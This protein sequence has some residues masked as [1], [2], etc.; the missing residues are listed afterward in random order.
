MWS[1]FSYFV[2]TLSFLT[3]LAS[4][5][6]AD[7]RPALSS[8]SDAR[9]FLHTLDGDT[10]Q[11]DIDEIWRLRLASGEDEPA[12]AIVVDYAFERL[13]VKD[14]FDHLIED[15]RG[16]RKI[17]RFTSPNGTPVYIL[18]RKV[19]GISRPIATQHHPN[20]KAVIIAREGQQ[21]VQE[22]RDAVRA[23]LDK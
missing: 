3:I 2:V 13:Y 18:P 12:G 21:Q 7:D 1:R 10:Q 20:T 15:I 17:E 4:A 5:A 19:I 23:A 11:V 16:Q 22:T 9:I 6:G 8:G 14:P